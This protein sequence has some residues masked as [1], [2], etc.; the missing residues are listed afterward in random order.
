MDASEAMEEMLATA[1]LLTSE[2]SVME[3]EQAEH[4]T[5]TFFL[6]FITKS[7][8]CICIILN[9]FLLKQGKQISLM[10]DQVNR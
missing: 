9:L 1:E 4:L 5:G 7:S 6:S 8:R 2:T 10:E 3:V